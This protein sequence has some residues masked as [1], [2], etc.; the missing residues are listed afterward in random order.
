MDF[1]KK[2]RKFQKNLANGLKKSYI[3]I[4]DDV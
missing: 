3:Y 2:F 1:F 4:H